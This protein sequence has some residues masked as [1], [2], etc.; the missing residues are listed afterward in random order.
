MIS[1]KRLTSLQWLRCQNRE[2]RKKVNFEWVKENL[3]QQAWSRRG[4]DLAR[5][6]WRWP[7]PRWGRYWPWPDKYFSRPILPHVPPG[8]WITDC[9]AKLFSVHW[10]IETFS[11]S[12]T[13]LATSQS[14]HHISCISSLHFS[15]LLSHTPPIFPHCPIFLKGGPNGRALLFPSLST[16]RSVSP[17]NV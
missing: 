2:Q 7:W 15:Q 13:S 11:T 1:K 12:N 10:Q 9:K 16:P 14:T 5:N 8:I 4:Y 3:Q 17:F 6:L